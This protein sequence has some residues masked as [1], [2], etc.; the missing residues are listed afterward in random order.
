MAST[1]AAGLWQKARNPVQSLTPSWC[2][3]RR[4]QY[5]ANWDFGYT[6]AGQHVQ[7]VMTSV[8][9]HLMELDFPASHKGWRSC[10]PVELFVAP[11]HKSVPGVCTLFFL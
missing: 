7:M 5:N 6:M 2:L 10:S 8:A 11:V 4:S 9:G 1:S 3:R